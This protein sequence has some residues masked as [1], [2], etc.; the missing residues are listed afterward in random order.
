MP[1]PLLNVE[2]QKI[3]RIRIKKAMSEHHCYV[4]C[5]YLTYL[6]MFDKC[7]SVFITVCILQVRVLDN[8]CLSVSSE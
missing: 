8:M 7:I 1:P 4:F 3:C 5:V 2:E 6:G